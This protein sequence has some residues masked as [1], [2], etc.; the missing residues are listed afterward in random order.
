LA[1]EYDQ[2]LD[3]KLEEL[4]QAHAITVFRPDMFQFYSQVLMSPQAYGFTNT[5]DPA[6]TSPG[7]DDEFFWWD[8]I[9]VT[10]SAH[11]ITSQEIYRQLMAE[12]DGA[13]LLQTERAWAAATAGDDLERVLSF[14]HDDAVVYPGDRAPV[15][16]KSEILVFLTANRTMPGFRQIFEPSEAHASPAGDLGYTVGNFET[17]FS[18]SEGTRL[19][20]SGRYVNVWRR[21]ADG[22][23]KSI[24]EVRSPLGPPA[25]GKGTLSDPPATEPPAGAWPDPSMNM[26]VETQRVILLQRDQDLSEALPGAI[27]AGAFDPILA[28]FREDA[29]LY[30][31]G[32]PAVEG[33]PAIRA[34]LE[35][36]HTQPGFSLTTA[37]F[38]AQ[39]SQSG[40]FGYTLGVYT[41]RFDAPDGSPVLTRGVD[42]SVWEKNRGGDWTTVLTMHSPT[43]ALGVSN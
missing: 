36:N 42:I 13:S 20:A 40:D 16:G 27:A 41:F 11:L 4:K 6:Q 17:S 9:H 35:A 32:S 8:G 23:W 3:Q 15:R 1:L 43:S 24:L 34:F 39:V 5:S 14:W 25:P 38:E 26:D 28:F 19:V 29:V 30:P 7:D 18:N 22:S 33:K 21:A 10:Q 37:P 31:S 12:A 2:A